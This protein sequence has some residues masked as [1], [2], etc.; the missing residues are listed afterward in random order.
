MRLMHDLV[1]ETLSGRYRLLT[2]LAGGGMGEVYRGHDTLLER[3][4]AV[5]V[6]QPSLAGDPSLVERF[7][8]EARTAARLTHP[9]VVGVYDWGSHADALYYMVMEYV[10]G[11]DLRDLL[12]RRGLLEPAQAVEVAAAVCDA[13]AVAHSCGLVHR[14]VK[15]EN[16]LLDR[17]GKVKVADFGIAVVVDQERTMPGG[18]LFGTLRYL[19][20]EQARGAEAGF[21]SDIWAVGAVLSEL[22]TGRPPFQ[23]TGVELL[24][25]RAEEPPEAPSA[26]E[27]NVPSELDAIVLKACALDPGERFSDASEMAN[28]LRRVAV[29]SLPDAPPLATLLDDVTGE[30]AIDDIGAPLSFE[31][32]VVPDPTRPEKKSRLRVAVGLFLLAVVLL[33]G[34]L[35]AA[36][37]LSFSGAAEVPDL[38][39]MSKA[40]ASRVA[41]D[42]GL[43]IAVTGRYHDYDIPK[44]AVLYQSPADGEVDEGSTVE[45]ALSL[46]LPFTDVPDVTGLDRGVAMVRL[47]AAGV[48]VGDVVMRYAPGAPGTVVR[49]DPVAGRHRW[50]SD[51]DLVVGKGPR[52]VEVP[53]VVGM[54]SNDATA[55]LEKAGLATVVNRVYSNDVAPGEIV[56]TAPTAGAIASAGDAVTIDVSNGPRFQELTMPDVR[57]VAVSAARRKLERAGLRV[58]EVKSCDNGDTVV[59]TDPIAGTRVRENDLVAVFVC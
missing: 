34:A 24:R 59:E 1:G 57:N 27:K 5:K 14:D 42:A 37:A 58:R 33:L 12:V 39:G 40:R 23:G 48:D 56:S 16:V 22:L 3:V 55:A 11:T 6:L 2:R 38:T 10:S 17:T 20:P 18:T 30:I 41:A 19:A 4:I 25:R 35:V 36:G 49:Q 44:G 31:H 45:I 29:R 50:G 53:D 9:N 7:K 26:Y 43:R 32:E 8:I 54:T 47:R 15:P 13:L 51:V 46:G 28:A 21:S 52:P